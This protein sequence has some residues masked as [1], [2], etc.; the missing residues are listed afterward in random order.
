MKR[1]IFELMLCSKNLRLCLKILMLSF[2]SLSFLNVDVSALDTQ[3]FYFSDFTADYYVSKNNEGVSEMRVVEKLTA[4]FP[5][6]NQNKGIC[7]M[8]PYLNNGGKNNTLPSLTK[9][10]IKVLRNGI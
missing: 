9:S 4:E 6:Y 10:D 8:I 1:G 3:N 5:D 7:R 2:L